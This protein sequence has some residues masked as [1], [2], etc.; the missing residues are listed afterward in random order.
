MKD[1]KRFHTYL[2]KYSS[3]N[4]PQRFI[5]SAMLVLFF[6]LILPTISVIKVRTKA[7]PLSSSSTGKI[8]NYKLYLTIRDDK[9]LDLSPGSL[10]EMEQT[11]NNICVVKVNSNLP[12]ERSFK[13]NTN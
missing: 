12:K 1:G 13:I 8:V 2:Q 11:A 4:K 9:I 3:Q 5:D 7:M 10:F 6:L